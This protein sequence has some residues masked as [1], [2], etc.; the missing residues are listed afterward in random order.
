MESHRDD[1]C[2]ASRVKR[3]TVAERGLW[4]VV[5]GGRTGA[6]RARNAPCSC[7]LIRQASAPESVRDLIN[8]LSGEVAAA[9]A[10]ASYE[11]VFNTEQRLRAKNETATCTFDGLLGLMGA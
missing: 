3:N 9:V 10:P 8:T 7:G 1:A 4:I 6:C 2:P 11:A 5:W